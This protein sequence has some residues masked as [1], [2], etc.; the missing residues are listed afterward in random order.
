MGRLWCWQLAVSATGA[1]T[2][3]SASAPT[4]SAAASGQGPQYQ[5]TTP[6]PCTSIP[7]ANPATPTTI[8]AMAIGQTAYTPDWAMWEDTKH[9][10]W[11]DAQYMVCQSAQG[12]LDMRVEHRAD[13]YH[14]WP[15]AGATYLPEGCEPDSG[16]S[17]RMF[18]PVT[19]A[20]KPAMP[21][22]I[23]AMA[24]GQTGYTQDWAMWQD[25]DHRFWLNSDFDL[26]ESLIGTSDMEVE[27]LKDGYHVWPPAD[28]SYPPSAT[29][30]DYGPCG[31]TLI[32]VVKIEH[33]G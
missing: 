23:G 5:A 8:G 27:R 10:F 16:Q 17:G 1:C 28:A 18:I 14:A 22:T 7:N 29:E 30:P 19:P 33:D 31:T 6:T 3:R 12:T 25:T 11:L 21:E 15:P 26:S 9:R 32:P 13:G 24:I 2:A 4:V 20:T